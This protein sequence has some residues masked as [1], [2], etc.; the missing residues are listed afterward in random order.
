MPTKFWT[1]NILCTTSSR[2]RKLYDRILPDKETLF[3]KNFHSKN[4]FRQWKS[5]V[6]RILDEETYMPLLSYFS[7]YLADLF[8]HVKYISD[9]ISRILANQIFC[10]TFCRKLQDFLPISTAGGLWLPFMH[11]LLKNFPDYK[12]FPCSN[13][14]TLQGVLGLCI[15]VYM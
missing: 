5:Y 11:G 10:Q 1:G 14:T 2:K 9:N 13:A 8:Q 4:I 15:L 12:N 6:I 3:A 7:T